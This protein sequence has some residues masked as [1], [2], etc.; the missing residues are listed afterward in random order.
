MTPW[1]RTSSSISTDGS[2]VARGERPGPRSTFDDYIQAITRR[3]FRRL[4]RNR[5]VH[6]LP[7][8]LQSH[9]RRCRG[10]R[11]GATRAR[12]WC[13]RNR[14]VT[15]ALFDALQREVQQLH[16]EH[17][18]HPVLV[19]D[20][21]MTASKY[22]VVPSYVRARTVRRERNLCADCGQAT[23]AVM[24]PMPVERGLYDCRFLAWLVVMKF[25]LLVPL[26]RIRTLLLSK[27]VDIAMGSLV[28]LVERASDL[29]APID[30][31]HLKQL[32]AGALMAFDGTG[33]K[34]LI[35]GY[36]GAWDGYFEVFTRDELTVFQFDVTKHADRLQRRM[37]EFAGFLVCDAESRNGTGAPKATLAHCNAHPLRR[38]REAVSAQPQLAA[39]GIGFIQE[40]YRLEDQADGLELGGA[41]RV[42]FRRR[43]SRP[44]LDR[45][46]KWLEGVR[47]G[48]LPPTD[49]VRK[50][51]VYYLNHWKG[52]TL[53][54]DHA[55]IPLDNNASE[56]EFQRHAKL[57]YAS[58]FAGSV[59]GAHR[60][61]TLLGVVRT[62]QKCEL[63]VEEYLVW[64]FE[65]RG[66]HRKRFGMTAAELTPMAYRDLL[67]AQRLAA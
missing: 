13:H 2:Q 1:S 61:A 15:A 17:H 35:D 64:A 47:D 55:E 24:P 20:D 30:G 32:R 27:G 53:F 43:H 62:A 36:E 5:V 45:F 29:V 50:V 26:D 4:A 59:E 33:L 10:A 42:A 52:L 28:S 6:L 21:C 41:E 39:E 16:H 67:T 58:L 31:E 48:P 37:Q 34:V 11:P 65:R 22:T 56:R 3:R 9:L 14:N 40:L 44:V 60:W 66:S 25:V 12:I 7:F 57:R 19:I 63:D 8:N 51:A 49:P 23:T 54:V 38:L 46:R 18:V